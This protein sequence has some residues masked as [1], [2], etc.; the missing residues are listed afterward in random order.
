[1]TP[2]MQVNVVNSYE[3]TQD[4]VLV[5]VDNNVDFPTDGKPIIATLASPLFMTSKPSPFSP[6]FPEGSNNC[7][8][9]LA[10]LA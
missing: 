9:Y 2:G 1:M 6:P 7:D 3:A 8:L 5:K 4:S 10:S